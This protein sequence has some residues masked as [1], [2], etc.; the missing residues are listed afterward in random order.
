ML[1]EVSSHQE[2]TPE[3]KISALQELLDFLARNSDSKDANL[4]AR[5]VDQ[6]RA[7][8]SKISGVLQEHSI[9]E[10]TVQSGYSGL[11]SVLDTMSQYGDNEGVRKLHQELLAKL[12]EHMEPIIAE[13]LKTKADAFFWLNLNVGFIEVDSKELARQIYGDADVQT[14]ADFKKTV[15]IILVSSVLG[16]PAS[17]LATMA[18]VAQ[19]VNPSVSFIEMIV[20]ILATATLH[21][22]VGKAGNKHHEK[23]SKRLSAK[24]SDELSAQMAKYPADR[25]IDEWN[26]S[27]KTMLLSDIQDPKMLVEKLLQFVRVSHLRNQIAAKAGEKQEIEKSADL[28]IK[29]LIATLGLALHTETEMSAYPALSSGPTQEKLAAEAEVSGRVLTQRI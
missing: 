13:R 19:A 9:P 11:K 3:E 29:E 28:D 23:E 1:A 12:T 10:L 7:V 16:I 2:Y 22:L 27:V 18:I 15:N 20:G 25:A 8:R 24:A 26:A 14:K 21:N 4:P 5:L 6:T 17:S